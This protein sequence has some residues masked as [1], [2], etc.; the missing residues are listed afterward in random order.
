MSGV[1]LQSSCLRGLAEGDLMDPEFQQRVEDAIALLRQE[2]QRELKIK[3]AAERLRRAV[4]NRKNAAD[5]DGQLRASS[6]KLEQ[7]HWELQE[8]NARAMATQKETIT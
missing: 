4:T 1:T 7:L 3:E 6:R 5:V 8:L 2:I